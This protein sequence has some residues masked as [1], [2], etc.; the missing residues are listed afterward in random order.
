MHLIAPCHFFQGQ[1]FNR[2]SMQSAAHGQ[3]YQIN[4]CQLLQCKAMAAACS[5]RKSCK[6]LF[7]PEDIPV[8][9]FLP[10][11]TQIRCTLPAVH[12]YA[13]KSLLRLAPF[14][15]IHGTYSSSIRKQAMINT[16]E[17]EINGC[18]MPD[19]GTQKY[20]HLV[21]NCAELPFAVSAK[22]DVQIFQKPSGK[23]HMPSSPEFP[24]TAADIRIIEVFFESEIQTSIP[25]RSPYHCIR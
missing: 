25:D 1:S 24:D 9:W 12:R 16:P 22:R 20:N 2:G 11:K 3:R 7:D 17:Q 23:R 21:D 15:T 18:S 10:G 8:P 6:H 14:F 13:G 19:T 5:I 4:R